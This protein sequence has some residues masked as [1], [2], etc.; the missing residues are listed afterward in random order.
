MDLEKVK[1]ILN[2][3]LEVP[4]TDKEVKESLEFLTRYSQLVMSNLLNLK[5]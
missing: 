5:K 2:K 4:L 1:V 3:N